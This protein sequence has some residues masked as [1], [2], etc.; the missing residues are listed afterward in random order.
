[1]ARHRLCRPVVYDD[2]FKILKAL[3]QNTL[4]SLIEISTQVVAGYDNRNRRTSCSHPQPFVHALGFYGN[5]TFA[6]RCLQ[7][8][9]L[10]AQY[11]VPLSCV[12]S[13]LQYGRGF[14]SSSERHQ[15]P[16]L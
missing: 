13:V 15:G 9:R 2:D 16:V 1:M 11:I 10:I 6:Q 4:N 12:H 7:L 14:A 3:I 8:Q 5:Q